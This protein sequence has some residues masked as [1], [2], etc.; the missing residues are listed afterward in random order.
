MQ[1][2]HNANI[3]HLNVII[4]FVTDKNAVM[5]LLLQTTQFPSLK[6]SETLGEGESWNNFYLYTYI[7]IFPILF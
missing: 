5:C 4:L 3:N 6:L 1:V 2:F 7:L